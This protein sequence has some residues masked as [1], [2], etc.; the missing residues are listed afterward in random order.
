MNVLLIF[1]SG[2]DGSVL[3]LLLPERFLDCV[4]PLALKK[5]HSILIIL[6]IIALRLK[7]D[8]ARTDFRPIETDVLNNWSSEKEK[9]FMKG[10]VKICRW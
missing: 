8:N 4:H 9:K 6:S 1:P 10:S 5:Y 3:A 2:A 7:G